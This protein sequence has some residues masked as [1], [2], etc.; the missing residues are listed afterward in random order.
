MDRIPL[1]KTMALR[2]LVGLAFAGL[3][4]LLA[5]ILIATGAAWPVLAA[6]V[7][8]VMLFRAALDRLLLARESD[9][10]SLPARPEFYDFGALDQPMHHEELAGRPL[11]SLNFVVFDT[12]TT[13]LSPS[14]GDEIVAIAGVRIVDGEIRRDGAFIRLVNPGRPIPKQSIRFHGITDEMVRGE[15]PAAEVLP[16]FHDFIEDAVLVAHN[17]AFDMK[18]LKLKESACGRRFDNLVLDTLLLS[19]FLDHDGHDHTLDAIAARYDVDVEGR[20]TALGDALVTASIF[21]RMLNIL[22]ARGVRTL[23]QAVD[24]TNKI[25]HVRKM[26]EKF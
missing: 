8:V 2:R 4:V 12:E 10:Q 26:Q 19:V 23:R 16:A 21:L 6:V 18:F 11:K 15:A 3:A 24:A 20:H 5:G 9:R 1:I 13:G 22:E 25:A 17:A 7:L 14:G